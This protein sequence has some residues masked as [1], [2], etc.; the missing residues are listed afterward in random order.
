MF[1][2]DNHFAVEI[3]DVLEFHHDNAHSDFIEIELCTPENCE[4]IEALF[5]EILA[6]H[7]DPQG[8]SHRKNRLF[9]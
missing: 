9:S 4:A 2:E 8:S 5:R 7:K 6:V 1:F 3:L